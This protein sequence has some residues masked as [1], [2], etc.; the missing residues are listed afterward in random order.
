MTYRQRMRVF[1]HV[2][3]GSPMFRKCPLK[4]GPLRI[5]FFHI[6]DDSLPTIVHVDVLDAHKLLPAV[7]QAAKDLNLGG[8]SSHQPGRSRSERRNPPLCSKTAIQLGENGHVAAL[9]VPAEDD[10][11][12]QPL[13]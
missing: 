6:A 5:G 4:L 3:F 10:R 11:V 12:G 13:E 8:I 7:T 9:P 2:G 1:T